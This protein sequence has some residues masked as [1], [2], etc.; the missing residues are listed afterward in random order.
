LTGSRADAPRRGEVR[1]VRV[2]VR[3]A[4]SRKR[5]ALACHRSQLGRTVTDDPDGFALSAAE[6]RALLGPFETLYL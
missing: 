4:L 3:A 6:R 2:D 5:A 1:T